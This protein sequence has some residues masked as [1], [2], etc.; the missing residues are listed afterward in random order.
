MVTACS[1]FNNSLNI[2]DPGASR[3]LLVKVLSRDVIKVLNA[4][5]PPL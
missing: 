5:K 4:A 2:R 3:R 1:T